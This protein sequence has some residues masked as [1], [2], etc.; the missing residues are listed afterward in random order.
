VGTVM[1]NLV[2]MLFKL[3]NISIK[4]HSVSKY[5]G[6]V[7]N[8]ILILI[9]IK[10]I[11]RISFILIERFFKNQS[12]LRFGM[13]EKKAKTL[14]ELLKSILRYVL[15]FIAIISILEII[16]PNVKTTLAL[17]GVFGVA[18]GFGSQ[19]LVKDVI[20][21]FFILFEDQFGVGDYVVIEGLSGNVETLGLR[22]TKIRDFSG[23]LHIIPNGSISKVTNKTR[24][25]M[26]ALVDVNIAYEEDIDNVTSIIAEVISAI[27]EEFS[28]IIEGPE[29]LG[30]TNFSESGVTVR[31]VAKTLP[32][33]QW[34]IEFELRK[35]IKSALD[36]NNIK[37][38]YPKRI[39]L[40]NRGEV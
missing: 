40:D 29:I 25:N 12:K 17:T 26:R 28:E 38:G 4:N 15:Y 35:R 19:S 3:F 2:N 30:V 36:I 8:I 10:I 23:D 9:L 34:K 22:V 31:I 27:K 7:L 21:G 1:P 33:M 5:L 39:I 11:I 6:I 18:V 20:A 37:M 24:G 32:M 16:W 14:S 13:N